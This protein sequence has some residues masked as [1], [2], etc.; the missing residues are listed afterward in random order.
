[1]EAKPKII[2][3]QPGPRKGP[4]EDKMSVT[5]APAFEAHEF[6]W[7]WREVARHTEE[8]LEELGLSDY[9]ILISPMPLGH[10]DLSKLKA[11]RILEEVERETGQEDNIQELAHCLLTGHRF[12]IQFNPDE[13]IDNPR[14][15]ASI[16]IV[17]MLDQLVNGTPDLDEL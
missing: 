10:D 12:E 13:P 9:D 17:D 4:L 7:L 1:M 15:F 14:E 2:A 6:A 5:I 8:C 16:Q 11:K 3:V